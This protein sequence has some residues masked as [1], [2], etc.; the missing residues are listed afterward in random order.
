MP[1][2]LDI[3]GLAWSHPLKRLYYFKSETE[4]DPAFLERVGMTRDTKS[5]LYW[6]GWKA[7]ITVEDVLTWAA[8][9]GINR[10]DQ[11][12]WLLRGDR[13]PDEELEESF[14]AGGGTLAS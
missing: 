4:T 13:S 6:K 5:I 12:D 14:A 2:P 3:E 1:A 10:S 7:R 11:L 9:L 8:N